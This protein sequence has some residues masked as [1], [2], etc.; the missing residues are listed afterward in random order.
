VYTC[1]W[2]EAGVAEHRAERH[3][4]SVG[5]KICNWKIII[6]NYHENMGWNSIPFK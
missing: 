5:L 3:S 1:T 2:E 6:C 4:F